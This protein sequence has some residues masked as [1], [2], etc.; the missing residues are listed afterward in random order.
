MAMARM[1]STPITVNQTHMTG[2]NIRPTA[3]VPS[4]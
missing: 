3:P 2:P 4:R 1:P